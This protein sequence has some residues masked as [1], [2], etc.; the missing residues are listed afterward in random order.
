MNVTNIS[1]EKKERKKKKDKFT[2]DI[3]FNL[4]P[5]IRSLINHPDDQ[6]RYHSINYNQ[7]MRK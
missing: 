2:Y 6:S 1:V 5:F 4:Y 7:S 3:S